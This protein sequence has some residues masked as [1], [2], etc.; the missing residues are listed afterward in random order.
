MWNTNI[1]SSIVQYILYVPERGSVERK[2]FESGGGQYSINEWE[3]VVLPALACIDGDERSSCVYSRTYCT[4]IS[5]STGASLLFSATQARSTSI[6]ERT[7]AAAFFLSSLFFSLGSSH[8]LSWN[9]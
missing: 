4:V 9:F 2:F 8:H 6:T 1:S 7:E 5:L 3:V